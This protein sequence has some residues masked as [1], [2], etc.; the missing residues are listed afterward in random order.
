LREWTQTLESLGFHVEA[1]R[2]NGGLPFANVML[3][4]R[5]G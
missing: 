2:M 3:I 4:A 1:A 5:L